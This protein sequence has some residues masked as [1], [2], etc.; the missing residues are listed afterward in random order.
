MS[1]TPQGHAPYRST[2]RSV[3]TLVSSA[4]ARLIRRTLLARAIAA[5][6]LHTNTLDLACQA[7][8][9]SPDGGIGAARRFGVLHKRYKTL[10]VLTARIA[11]QA[12]WAQVA[13]WLGVTAETAY[14]LYGDAERRW[15]DGDPQPWAP[16]LCGGRDTA[17]TVTGAAPIVIDT[18]ADA[19]AAAADLARTC[20][21]AHVDGCACTLTF[22][23]LPA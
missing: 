5:R 4:D 3:A 13:T 16:T 23:P 20:A 18:E 8:G 2:I 1:T 10:T 21:R 15:R 19:D 9:N 22:P 12:T 11:Q 7:A 6:D 17:T 14:A